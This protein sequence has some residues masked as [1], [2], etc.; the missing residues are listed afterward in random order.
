MYVEAGV[1]IALTGVVVKLIDVAYAYI[2][3]KTTESDT[4]KLEKMNEK[5]DKVVKHTEIMEA[6]HYKYDENGIPLWYVPRTMIT[7]QYESKTEQM[8]LAHSQATMSRSMERMT[9]SLENIVK[10]LTILEER[11]SNRNH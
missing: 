11:V 1:M 3:N 9:Q 8:N 2:K 10:I 4:S 6:L 5:I 7:S